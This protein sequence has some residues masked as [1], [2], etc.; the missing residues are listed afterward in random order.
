MAARP[1]TRYAD[2]AMTHLTKRYEGQ[3]GDAVAVG[4]YEDGVLVALRRGLVEGVAG[5]DSR[6]GVCHAG[7]A[8]GR[9]MWFL[10]DDGTRVNAKGVRL[11]SDEYL[12]IGEWGETWDVSDIVGVGACM[13]ALG[14]RATSSKPRDL[15]QF[16]AP[17]CTL[18]GVE[19]ATLRFRNAADQK[20]PE[21]LAHNGLRK[22]AVGALVHLGREIDLA[23]ANRN[24]GATRR[25]GTSLAT[26][27][28]LE[29]IHRA[30]ITSFHDQFLALCG[31]GMDARGR[32]REPKSG[33]GRYVRDRY[34]EIRKD[35]LAGDA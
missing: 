35:A 20:D 6:V 21:D 12:L 26:I 14:S 10:R 33:V 34:V 2:A 29:G 5:R 3:V 18:F 15:R 22:F 9:R 31:F 23:H 25:A 11:V 19:A 30:T 24:G 17:L 7:D 13:Q 32:A 28:E 16:V 4:Q 8:E 27:A 1:M